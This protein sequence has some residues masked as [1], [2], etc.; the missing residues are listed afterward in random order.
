MNSAPEGILCSQ[1]NE[2][3]LEEEN[4][5]FSVGLTD[6]YIEKLGDVV[7]VELP[8]AGSHFLKNEAFATIESIKDASEIY[9]PISGIVTQVN[10]NLINSPELINE[11]AFG[12]WLVKI[13][14]DDFQNDSQGLMD[15]TDYIDEVQ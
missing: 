6:F 4:N 1:T 3:I 14:A 10:E 7:F 8:E 13:K 15:Y 12:A 9:M 5:I 11:D 2:W